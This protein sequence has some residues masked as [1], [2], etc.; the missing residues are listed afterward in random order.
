MKMVKSVL[1]IL[2]VL[3]LF[4]TSCASAPAR[5]GMPAEIRDWVTKNGDVIMY[6][7]GI[8]E[9][10]SESVALQ[11]ATDRARSDLAGNLSTDIA[12]ISKDFVSINSKDTN[13]TAA[14][15]RLAK[16]EAGTKQIVEATIENA[17]TVGPYV[18]GKRNTYIIKY[19]DQNAVDGL[20]NDLAS[21]AKDVFSDL[22]NELNQMLGN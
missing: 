16:F 22:E 10:K 19:L 4:F 11:Q 21:N 8:S 5:G 9:E 15:Q 1:L 20:K 6:G 12:D 18:N 3:P 13:G 17:R 14:K 7:M 2:V